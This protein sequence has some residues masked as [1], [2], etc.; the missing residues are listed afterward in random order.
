MCKF[1]SLKKRADW[2]LFYDM[3][4]LKLLQVAAECLMQVGRELDARQL[5]F[6]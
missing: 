1:L 5:L 6:S 4:R 3:L 2:R